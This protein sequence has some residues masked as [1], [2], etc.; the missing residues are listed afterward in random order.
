MKNEL[1]HKHKLINDLRA[2]LNSEASSEEVEILYDATVEGERRW[3]NLLSYF[4]FMLVENPAVLLIGEAPGY[5][6]TSISG[7]PFLSEQMIREREAQQNN[8]LPLIEYIASSNYDS[9]TG[10]E[11]T[12]TAMWDAIDSVHSQMPLLWAVFPN[13]PH[14][15]NNTDSNRKPRKSEISKYVDSIKILEKIYNIKEIVAVGNV[16][17]ETLVNSGYIVNKIRHPARGGS[18]IFKEGYRKIM[19]GYRGKD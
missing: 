8:K 9:K 12:S 16:A 15:L 3:M 18:K 1:G 10:Y 19:E 2:L 4:N 11:A 7:V 13:H 5:R 14:I 6:G 17:Y